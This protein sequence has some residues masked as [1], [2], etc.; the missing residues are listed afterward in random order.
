[1][2]GNCDFEVGQAVS[3]VKNANKILQGATELTEIHGDFFKEF[4][5]LPLFLFGGNSDYI[6][7]LVISYRIS[8]IFFTT[9]N[10]PSFNS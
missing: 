5:L 2:A 8:T 3:C 9:E 4:K 6:L 1:M 7:K 10:L